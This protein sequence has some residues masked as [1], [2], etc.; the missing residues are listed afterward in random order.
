MLHDQNLQCDCHRNFW[1]SH[2]FYLIQH[3][4]AEQQPFLLPFG[5][6]IADEI[7]TMHTLKFTKFLPNGDAVLLW[8]S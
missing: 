8:L 7:E 4:A 2:L 3:S 1:E 5:N 6:T